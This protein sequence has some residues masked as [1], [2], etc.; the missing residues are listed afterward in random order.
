MLNL[1]KQEINPKDIIKTYIEDPADFCL[2]NFYKRHN[3]NN[4]MFSLC[5]LDVKE[6]NPELYNAYFNMQ[7]NQVRLKLSDQIDAVDNILTGISTGL[8]KEGTDFDILEFYKFAPCKGRFMN[9]GEF[10]CILRRLGRDFPES[11][12][13]F[14]RIKQDYRAEMNIKQKNEN[15]ANC[16]SNL[17]HVINYAETL[18]LFTKWMFG[19][20]K[21][22]FLKNYMDFF[23]VKNITPIGMASEMGLYIGNNSNSLYGLDDVKNIFEE[24]DEKGYPKAREVYDILKSDLISKRKEKSSKEPKKLQYINTD[25]KLVI[26]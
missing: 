11:L 14:Q 19:D 9:D 25:N 7:D 16:L 1:K 26:E 20:E 2:L 6:N 17:T 18:Y 23:E 3:I 21:A 24:M 10:D 22:N 15:D 8:T 4:K 5:V 13:V 12:G